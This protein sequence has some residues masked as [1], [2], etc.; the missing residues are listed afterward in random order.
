MLSGWR[1]R[2]FPLRRALALREAAFGDHPESAHILG[3][4]GDIQFARGAPRGA[5][6]L[7]ERAVAL[8]SRDDG[9]TSA[10]AFARFQLARTLVELPADAGRDPSRARLLPRRPLR[11]SSA[12][13]ATEEAY[14]AGRAISDGQWSPQVA[15][16]PDRHPTSSCTRARRMAPSQ[17]AGRSPL[18][19][20]PR[21]RS[22]CGPSLEG[23]M[24]RARELAF[25][26]LRRRRSTAPRRGLRTCSLRYGALMWV[27]TVSMPTPRS[28]RSPC[29]CSRAPSRS[30]R[31]ARAT[32]G[33]A[34]RRSQCGRPRRSATRRRR[35]SGDVRH[36]LPAQTVTV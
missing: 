18:R 5:L 35:D 31:R 17:R 6:P 33:G 36:Q 4:L 20:T 24:V 8:A 21:G 7:L 29:S 2:L 9:P 3:A 12:R 26:A 11:P 14:R 19:R 28:R 10:L 16:T 27:R 34:P 13:Y 30:G 15:N 32:S 22:R 25:T 1:E 23:R